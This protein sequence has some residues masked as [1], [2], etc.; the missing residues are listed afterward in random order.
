[1]C[2][3]LLLF[4]IKLF[5]IIIIKFY[6]NKSIQ[7][8]RVYCIVKIHVVMFDGTMYS[9]G[10]M[11][12][13]IH[14]ETKQSELFYFIRFSKIYLP[15]YVWNNV[16]FQLIKDSSNFRYCLPSE[17]DFHCDKACHYANALNLLHVENNQRLQLIKKKKINNLYSALLRTVPKASIQDHSTA[18][19]RANYCCIMCN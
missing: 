3:I 7:S 19:R 4:I 5:L 6:F 13:V 9:F 11:G 10:F 14:N 18:S 2:P 8:Y 17:T 12:H 1:M 15:L 16:S